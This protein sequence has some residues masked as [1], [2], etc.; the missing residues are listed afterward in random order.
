[1]NVFKI[2]RQSKGGQKRSSKWYGKVRS[3]RRW[4]MVALYSDRAAS[5]RQLQELQKIEDQKA[6]GIITVAT[7][8]A[9]KP[10][11]EHIKD[12]LSDLERQGSS[13]K[14]VYTMKV[15]FNRVMTLMKW[16]T[17][18][19]LTADNVAK[20]LDVL[21]EE[22]LNAQT[23]NRYI[24]HLKGLVHWCQKRGR[25]GHDP[26]ISIQKLPEA[27]RQRVG[28]T[29]EQVNGLL[30]AAP[31]E[32]AAVY[33]FAVLT[34]LRRSELQALR[35]G[36]LHLDAP[37]PFIQLRADVTK[38]G[39]ADQLPLHAN[40]IALLQS[41]K[42]KQVEDAIFAQIPSMKDFRRDL[43]AAGLDTGIDFHSLRHTYCQLLV[44]AGVS[45][46]LAQQLM[47]HSDPR[48]TSNI[49]GRMGIL[50]TSK[51]V[52]DINL[53]KSLSTPAVAETTN[54]QVPQRNHGRN[55]EMCFSGHFDTPACTLDRG[56][57]G[58]LNDKKTIENTGVCATVHSDAL[59]A[60][61]GI[62][63]HDVQ[64]GKLAFYR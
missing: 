13:P 45:L 43:Q 20:L 53:G 42:P 61:D 44:R 22:G 24:A 18:A 35:W 38:N 12:R 8:A 28:L 7:E 5:I 47:R 37:A 59:K 2:T 46:K 25:L 6:S 26:L 17:L 57:P 56:N 62:R 1:M 64:L 49:Y 58:G 39:K 41:W 50:D 19:D 34:G 27:P 40:L 33:Q 31:P 11:T 54:S 48:L 16:R 10:L 55:H 29:G 14:H 15:S 32:R 36:D 60:G 30:A 21:Q 63:T 51:A 52:Q 4:R 23:I 3:G 9:A